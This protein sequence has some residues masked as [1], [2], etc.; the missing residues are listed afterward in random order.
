[1]LALIM[2]VRFLSFNIE[3]LTFKAIRT[4][5]QPKTI[6]L[7]ITPTASYIKVICRIICF[8]PRSRCGNINE[9]YT[10]FVCDNAFSPV[11][12]RQTPK[13]YQDVVIVRVGVAMVRIGLLSQVSLA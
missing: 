8:P 4:L 10:W 13:K 11:I 12:Y 3:I 5:V 7:K 9:K 6:P 2:H 1:M